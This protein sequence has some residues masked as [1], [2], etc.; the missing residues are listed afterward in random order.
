MSNSARAEGLRRA[1]TLPRG[2]RKLFRR[3]SIR[4]LFTRVVQHVNGFKA[5]LNKERIVYA[6]PPKDRV[7]GVTGL[8]NQGNTCFI[9]AVLQCLSHTDLLAEYLVLGNY[10]A[11]LRKSKG[12]LTEQ[13]AALLRAVWSGQYAPE[14]SSSFK[15][16]VDKYGSQYR[17]AN[18]H[19]AQEFLL[20]LLD[21]V[22][23][24]LNTATKK[25]YKAI[26]NSF[27]RPDAIVAEET[28]ANHKRC[29]NSFVHSLF[30][31]QFR[32]SLTCPKCQRQSN[33]FDPFLCVSIPVPQDQSKPLFVSVVYLS[34]QPRQVRIG[35]SLPI[36]A[37]T[38]ELR[39]QLASDTGI[40]EAFMLLTEIDNQGFVR[41]L[42]DVQGTA[43]ASESDP[44]YC[45]ELPQLKDASEES[46]AY[47]MLVWINVLQEEE[48]KFKRFGSPYTMQVTRETS[49]EDLQ[50]LILKE[51]H[52]AL[53]DDILTN[54]QEVP[55]FRMRV[56]E[57]GLQPGTYLDFSL[58]HPL[59]MEAVDQALALC[60]EDGG[61]AHLKLVLEWEAKAK[62]SV[63]ADDSEQ[64]EELASVRELK[65]F[66]EESRTATLEECFKLYTQDEVLGPEDAWH[67]PYCN[68]KQEVVKKL[69]LWSLPDILIIHLKRFRQSPKSRSPSK[70][71]TM[72]EFPLF[73]FDMSPHVASKPEGA[74]PNGV[75][76]SPWKRPR[77]Q[78]SAREDN[79]Y[80]LYAVCN[81]HGQDVQ[82]GHYTA[83][84]RN[85]YDGQWYAFDDAKVEGLEEE[86]VVTSSAYILF[87]QHRSLSG[88]PCSS[89]AS[90]SSSSDHWV[91]RIPAF[92]AP[93]KSPAETPV[94]EAPQF[95]RNS[96]G[97]ATLP[98]SQSPAPVAAAEKDHHSEDEAEVVAESSV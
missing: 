76:W 28:L 92:D 55:L 82:G 43:E 53:H 93:A 4:R 25:K 50:K 6:P 68:R 39:E 78:S 45:I 74:V 70:L 23:E 16:A 54:A 79:V 52:P 88:S 41:T 5:P 91:C 30:Q 33:T 44:L 81:H 73:G 46:G 72:V 66:T 20:W 36:D 49:Y 67:C 35:L 84:C 11:D 90:T 56:A 2:A 37:E 18:Q 87:Y 62:E 96:R 14:L 42:S 60:P 61:P 59:Y 32:S 15:T 94:E 95:Q 8:R 26:K 7:P 12:E 1:F 89:S 83:Y 3:P 75:G 58:D 48:N 22:H 9:N 63:I 47:V 10:K 34:Q 27:G 13:L 86:N 24:D 71:S 97:Y 31:A 80:D 85:P 21:K 40:S 64:E 29:N 17:G 38:K 19:D 51:M 69:G 77:R 65:N 98:S 57:A